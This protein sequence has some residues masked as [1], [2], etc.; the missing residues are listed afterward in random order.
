MAAESAVDH[1]NSASHPC[2]ARDQACLLAVV[3]AAAVVVACQ[4]KE[5]ERL[6]DLQQERR[7]EVVAL[8]EIQAEQIASYCPRL[9]LVHQS[10]QQLLLLLSNSHLALLRI[11]VLSGEQQEARHWLEPAAADSLD[12]PIATCRLLSLFETSL[13]ELRAS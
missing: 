8:A 3:E 2:K 12:I 13:V 9:A 10:V 11:D 7:I 4:Y 5:L 6:A 1:T